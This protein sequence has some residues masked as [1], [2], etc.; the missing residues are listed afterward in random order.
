MYHVCYVSVLCGWVGVF[1]MSYVVSFECVCVCVYW[2]CHIVWVGTIVLDMP[3]HV[4][5][6]VLDISMPSE[7]V[8]CM[9]YV[10]LV[11]LCWICCVR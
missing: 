5:E 4:V 7:S 3:C 11:S 6:C 10:S 8:C 9:C 1:D 2:I